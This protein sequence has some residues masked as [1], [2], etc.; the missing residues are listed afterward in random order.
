VGDFGRSSV[1]EGR[2]GTPG[3]SVF[4]SGVSPSD[5]AFDANG[6]RRRAPATTGAEELG[7]EVGDVVVHGTWGEGRVVATGGEGEDAEA[8]V[9]FTS[10]GRKKLLLRMAPVKRA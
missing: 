3:R 6:R 7:L 8:E 2:S 10:V 4:G 9:I 5:G 1:A